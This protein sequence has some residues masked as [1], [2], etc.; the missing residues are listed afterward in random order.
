MTIK[1]TRQVARQFRGVRKILRKFAK[2]WDIK[3][4]GLLAVTVPLVLPT[5]SAYSAEA[6]KTVETVTVAAVTVMLDEAIFEPSAKTLELEI[7]ESAYQARLKAEAAKRAE[8]VRVAPVSR[9]TPDP[10][11]EVKR[12]WVKQAAAAW[13]I[14]WKVLEAVWQVES[15]KRW[16]SHVRSYAGATGPCQFMLGTW[17]AYGQDGNGDGVKDINDARDC[18]FAA[19]KLL[20]VNGAAEGD[21]VRALR[22][23]NNSMS[24]VLKVLRVADSIED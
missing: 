13:G 11:P 23:Y 14:D 8:D 21:Y 20:A 9:A 16:Y 12:M 24:Y 18:L 19:A 4:I 10:G 15:G 3:K 5:V 17:R 1:S 22:R 6:P 7:V 2:L